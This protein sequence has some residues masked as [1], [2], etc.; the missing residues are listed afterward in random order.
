MHFLIASC[1]NFPG[2]KLGHDKLDNVL[3]IHK[4]SL[5][6]ANIESQMNKF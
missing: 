3:V 2:K 4:V 1:K 6:T 5:N